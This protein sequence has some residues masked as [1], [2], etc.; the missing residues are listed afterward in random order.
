MSHLSWGHTPF[1]EVVWNP[2]LVIVRVYKPGPMSQCGTALKGH[3]GF[4]A[5]CGNGRGPVWRHC[6]PFSLSAL[7]YFLPFPLK[8]TPQVYSFLVAQWLRIRLPMQGTWVQAL[9]WEDPTCRRATKP[10]CLNY[11]AC[12]L[13]PASHNCWSLHSRAHEPQL[14]KPARLEPMLRKK[15]SHCDEKPT[16]RNK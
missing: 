4:I 3:S 13:E 5:P 12:T 6:S 10:V 14:L 9:V 16:H 1:P 8:S 2:W 15:R 7:S 11:W